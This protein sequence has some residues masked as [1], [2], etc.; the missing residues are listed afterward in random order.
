MGVKI[1]SLKSN[2]SI[3]ELNTENKI[4]NSQLYSIVDRQRRGK[5]T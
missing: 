3:V 5:I 2:N 1:K 4:Y